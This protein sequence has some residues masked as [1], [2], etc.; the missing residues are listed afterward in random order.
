MRIQGA[1]L[2]ARTADLDTI[3]WALPKSRRLALVCRP[4]PCP[5]SRP[6]LKTFLF[7]HVWEVLL[8]LLHLH[9][10]H[11]TDR[12]SSQAN[13][14]RHQDSVS[15][16]CRGASHQHLRSHFRKTRHAQAV[17]VLTRSPV[18][19]AAEIC[20]DLAQASAPPR[21]LSRP[22]QQSVRV[23]DEPDFGNSPFLRTHSSN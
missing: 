19:A 1:W 21:R 13:L 5:S 6:R 16:R 11:C 2:C 9:P 23:A 3:G 22:W 17:R 8:L 18:L 12:S 7:S 4:T 20:C 14:S 10:A 15:E